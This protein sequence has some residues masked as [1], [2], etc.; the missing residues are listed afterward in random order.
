MNIRNEETKDYREVEELTRQA[1]WNL[2]SPGCDE[3]Y[4]VHV[5]RGHADFISNL[6]FVIEHE[7]RIIANIMF[8]K[9]KLVEKNGNA[10]EIL[11][12]GPLSVLPEYQRKGY[13]RMLVEHS[14]KKAVEMGYDTIVIFG[15]PENYIPF[16]FKSSKHYNIYVGN[17]IFP[18]ALLVKELCDVAIPVGNWEFHES[19]IY[20]LDSKAVE[21]FDKTFESVAKEYKQSQELFYIYSH[22][23]VN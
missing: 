3:H 6:D 10:K 19:P 2:H 21:E 7:G 20:E 23:Q 13:G 5:M 17:N 22:S 9:A 15:N 14:F 11:T 16:G 8:T 4:L 12:F 1:F 18:T